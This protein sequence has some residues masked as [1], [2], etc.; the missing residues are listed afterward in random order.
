MKQYN[1]IWFLALI[2]AMGFLFAGC[3]ADASKG[4]GGPVNS[5]TITGNDLMRFNQ[6]EFTV[7]AGSEVTVVFQNA[8]RMPK[9]TMGHNLVILEQGVDP[10]AFS[11]ASM[12]HPAANY[13]SPDYQDKVIAATKI[14]G[15]GESE[16]LTFTAPSDPGKYPYVCSFPGHTPAGMKG[17][18]IVQ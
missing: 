11:T 15:P 17:L 8:G 5:I 13:I 2:A 9:E 7:P 16:T 4:P 12:A 14:L 6:T 10:I 3:G 1:T 18:M